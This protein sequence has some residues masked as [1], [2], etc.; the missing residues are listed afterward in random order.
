MCDVG[1]D[2]PDMKK[3]GFNSSCKNWDGYEG[4]WVTIDSK[5]GWFLGGDW[6]VSLL[7]WFNPELLHYQPTGL[8][9][10]S[11]KITFDISSCFDEQNLAR[12]FQYTAMAGQE[13]INPSVVFPARDD[14]KNSP[15][16]NVVIPPAA[17]LG[18]NVI[19][20]TILYQPPGDA[21]TVSFNAA[22]T[23]STQFNIAGSKNVVN[24][25]TTSQTSS[26]NFAMDMAFLIGFTGASGTTE[27]DTTEKDFGTQQGGGPQGTSTT[28]FSFE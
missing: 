28:A 23:Y 16:F 15:S 7:P 19:P 9:V 20:Y 24:K 3:K 25:S 5:C 8:G 13:Q 12:T 17:M 27:T 1:S 22:K 4:V 10:D 18:T 14:Y 11:G 6:T 21:S 2:V 26:T